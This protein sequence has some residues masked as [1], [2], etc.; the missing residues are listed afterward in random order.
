M[1]GSSDEDES[2]TPSMV[3]ADGELE[4][5]TAES[6]SDVE[7]DTARTPTKKRKRLCR[8]RTDWELEFPWCHSVRGQQFVAECRLCRKTFSIAH[9]GRSD[10]V[11]A[12]NQRSP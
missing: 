7:H 12:F 8:Y 10:V 6:Q 4:G 3:A 2:K 5:D 9:G 11:P 1:S